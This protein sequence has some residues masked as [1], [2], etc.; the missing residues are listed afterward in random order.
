MAA[1]T[2]A[3]SLTPRVFAQADNQP[4]RFIVPYSAGGQTDVIAR[5]IA[6]AMQRSL[7]RTIYIENRPGAAGLI[8]LRALQQAK[9][10]GGTVLIQ[11]SGILVQPFVQKGADYNV[12]TDFTHVA[13]IGNGLNVLIIT[14]VVPAKTLA[15]FLTYARARPGQIECGNSGVNTGGHILAQVLEKLGDISLLHVPFKGTADISVA[16]IAGQIR[17]QMSVMSDALIPYVEEGR[18]RILGVTTQERSPFLPDV[19]S[20]GEVVQGYGFP[21]WLGAFAP[22][23]T[24]PEMQLALAN[25]M[26]AAL[27]EASVQTKLK[28]LFM[29]PKFAG[30]DRFRE[31][32]VQSNQRTS[33]TVAGLLGLRPL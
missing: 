10:D 11:N 18:M 20:I 17:M 9:P 29:E 4:L 1:G 22:T 16:M 7:G 3:A 14:D 8:A 25:A 12:L 27:A 32:I 15:E 23:G 30:P 2:V 33:D 31:V 5:V 21:S 24:P 13:Q 28:E 6:T 26:E 19:P